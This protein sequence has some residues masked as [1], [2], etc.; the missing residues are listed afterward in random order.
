MG[1]DSILRSMPH[2]FLG[3]ITGIDWKKHLIQEEKMDIKEIKER[4]EECKRLESEDSNY[5]I[6]PAGQDIS[7]LLSEIERLEKEVIEVTSDLNMVINT[8]DTYL[9][10][11]NKECV[12]LEKKICMLDSLNTVLENKIKRLEKENALLKDVMHKAKKIFKHSEVVFGGSKAGGL[13]TMFVLS[14]ELE[15]AINKAK[16]EIK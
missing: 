8:Q 9:Q 11:K 7:F 12:E 15:E 10:K 14:K 2:G 5:V 16:E 1:M 13:S 4:M 6:S 3:G